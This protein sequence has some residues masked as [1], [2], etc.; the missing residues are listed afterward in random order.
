M[1]FIEYVKQVDS[2]KKNTNISAMK[3]IYQCYFEKV[4]LQRHTVTEICPDHFTNVDLNIKITAT[5]CSRHHFQMEKI[6]LTQQDIYTYNSRE[7]L[8]CLNSFCNNPKPVQ[9]TSI[10]HLFVELVPVLLLVA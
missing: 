5:D 10:E 4:R 9:C 7:C 8:K 6:L 2:L 3:M 1:F